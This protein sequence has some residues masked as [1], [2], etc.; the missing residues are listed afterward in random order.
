MYEAS[1]LSLSNL[2]Q[3]EE[4]QKKLFIFIE[5]V[6]GKPFTRAAGTFI[7]AALNKNEISDSESFFCRYDAP[8]PFSDKL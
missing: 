6:K 8:K 7:K 5:S 4:R 1:Q 2:L 3:I